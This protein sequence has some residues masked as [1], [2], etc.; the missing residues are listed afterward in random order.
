[1]NILVIGGTYF[2]GK[3]FVEKATAKEHHICLLNRG[4][5]NIDVNG[6][7]T[8]FHADRH[9][10]ERLALLTEKEFDVIVDF[11]GYCEGDIKTIVDIPDIKTRQYIF[12]STC[13]VYRR[14]TG[15]YM[16]ETGEL[17]DR[18]FGGEAGDYISG[19]VALERELRSC[20]EEKSI[21]YTSVR[22]AFI[23]GKD[24]YAPREGIY[25]NWIQ[26]AGQIIHPQD[27]DGE[28]QMV[29]VEDVADIILKMCL[30]PKAYDKVYNLCGDKMVNYDIFA[31]ALK[32]AVG[33]NFEKVNLS[34][35]DIQERSI[36]LPFPLTK[37]ESQYYC[38]ELVKE[39]LNV[40]YTPLVQGLKETYTSFLF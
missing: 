36:P 6:S 32:Q 40:S 21:K 31:D 10:T 39:D 15:R 4:S 30:N 13:D 1:M 20:C 3:A 23:Y 24:N 9:D 17:E 25:F 16:D 5:R 2:L 27:A 22:P 35:K 7:I 14:D 29:Y 38:G 8:Q 26:Q 11:C 18:Y 37:E 33:I 19:K 34:V 28:F 12:V